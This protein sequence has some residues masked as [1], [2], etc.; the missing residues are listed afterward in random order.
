MQN[1]RSTAT[2]FLD[3]PPSCLEFCPTGPDF[4]VVGT[5]LLSEKSVGGGA[6]V[7]KKTGSLQLWKFNTASLQLTQSHYIPLPHAVFDLHFHPREQ[8]LLAVATSAASVSLY[9]VEPSST[10]ETPVFQHIWTIPV[11]EDPFSPVLFLAWAPKQFL[12]VGSGFAVTFSDGTTSFFSTDG[13]LIEGKFEE[14]KFGGRESSIEVWFV[15]LATFTRDGTHTEEGNVAES[16]LFTGDDFGA[17]HML[18]F[19]PEEAE[20]REH[21]SSND[22][23]EERLTPVCLEYNDKARHHTAGVTAILP[24]PISIIDGFP[25][26]LTGSYDEFIRV[27][28]ATPTGRVLT[29]TRLEGGVWRLQ[30]LDSQRRAI[31]PSNSADADDNMSSHTYLILASCMHAGTRLLRVTWTRRLGPSSVP[32]D[33][34]QWDIEI[35]AR[36]TE[37]RSMNY[38]SDVWRGERLNVNLKGAGSFCVSS[39][40]YDRRLCL[41]EIKDID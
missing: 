15:A 27:Y 40:F 1:L 20:G 2:V 36:F 41:W 5:Y 25:V 14:R 7:Q 11:H 28:H 29:E 23:H 33:Q 17:L 32:I 34:G 13:Q 6:I 24:L 21:I 31:S 8:T 10:T 9:R 4:F 35:L 18:Q 16:F 22:D 37:H 38:A 19:P 39:S 26:L 12:H 30:L 3:S